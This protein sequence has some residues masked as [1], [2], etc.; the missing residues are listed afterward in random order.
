[1]NRARNISQLA[2]C[3]F[4]F[5]AASSSVAAASATPVSIPTFEPPAA[6]ALFN[7]ALAPD[8]PDR[9]H[10]KNGQSLEGFVLYEDRQSLVIRI[11]NRE[12]EI[13]MS[14]VESV[15]SLQRKRALFLEQHLR[16]PSSSTGAFLDLA[17][18]CMTSGLVAEARLMM[19]IVLNLDPDNEQAHEALEHRKQDTSYRAMVAGRWYR[20]SEVLE[21]S[22]DW[23]QAWEFN[24]SH[25]SM[26]SNLPMADAVN[27]TLDLERFYQQYYLEL[28]ES[29]RLFEFEEPLKARIH[30]DSKSFP[31]LQQNRAAYYD[32]SNDS[33]VVDASQTFARPLIIHEATHQLLEL[34]VRE[35]GAVASSIP[36]WLSEGLA[37][38]FS[39]A[40]TGPAGR[41]RFDTR[42]H[43]IAR[44]YLHAH[45]EEPF[46]LD[47]ILNLEVGDFWGSADI[48]LMYA[49][50]Y[51]LVHFCLQ[52]ENQRFRE[53]MLEYMSKVYAGKGTSSLFK[54]IVTKR[55]D[56][57]E[58]EWTQYVKKLA[59]GR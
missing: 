24:S 29:L 5:L 45:A 41:A 48:D 6:G 50:A 23:N 8:P 21:R 36:A 43:A 18:Y 38:Y 56:D 14:E 31:K 11:N 51:T 17:R 34:T 59:G 52:G 10:L 47:R 57:F 32:R 46:S 4:S 20:W 55:S 19:L 7:S 1:M 33:L 54:K 28:Q 26:R 53:P 49:Q 39:N 44:I 15:D 2:A 9:V 12:K 3:V 35:R 16:L 22:K 30:F 27:A 37:E 42:R 58:A 40:I 13:D 25:Y